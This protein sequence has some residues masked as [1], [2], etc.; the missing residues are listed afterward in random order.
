MKFSHLWRIACVLILLVIS[1]LL[2][3][4]A[5]GASPQKPE[6]QPQQA[7]WDKKS[8]NPAALEPT[9]EP[10]RPADSEH[11]VRITEANAGQLV[12]LSREQFLAVT[13]EANPSTGYRWEAKDTGQV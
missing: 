11:E 13:L 4:S 5:Y 10:A 6:G 9:P 3:L 7:A 12:R 2:A 1:F 8:L